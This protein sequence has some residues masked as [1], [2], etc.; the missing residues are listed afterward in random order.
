MATHSSVLAWRVPWTEE[1]GGLQSMGLQRVR[2]ACLH[3]VYMW[4][5][6]PYF[7]QSKIQS[8]YRGEQ[9]PTGP[10]SPGLHP[11]KNYSSEFIFPYSAPVPTLSTPATMDSLIVKGIRVHHAKTGHFEL[12]VISFL[13]SSLNLKARPTFSALKSPS[14]ILERVK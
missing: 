12:K 5:K 8:F 2:H 14:S 9:C 10:G 4:K 13:L 1:P 11:S 7:F 6:D 3:N